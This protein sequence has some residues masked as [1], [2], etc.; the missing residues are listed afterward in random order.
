MTPSRNGSVTAA[1]LA[2]GGPLP[3]GRPRTTCSDACRQAVWRRRHQPPPAVPDL[4]ARQPRKP[5]TVYHCDRCD[6]RAVGAQRCQECNAF[7][8]AVGP[9]GHCP[10]CDEPITFD[11]L[12][13]L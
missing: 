9:G 5:H 6:T 4:P 13:E 11:E 1:C 7:M 8:R 12:L 2:C 3:P 10:C